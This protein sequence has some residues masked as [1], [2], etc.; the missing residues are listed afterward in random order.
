[1]DRASV[2]VVCKTYGALRVFLARSARCYRSGEVA[3]V[4]CVFVNVCL[5]SG[6]VRYVALPCL[7]NFACALF[8]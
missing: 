6:V 8:M 2:V 5:L 1:M 4:P 3:L 7:V